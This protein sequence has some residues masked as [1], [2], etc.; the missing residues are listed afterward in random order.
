MLSLFVLFWSFVE[1]YSIFLV[2]FLFSIL[3]SI[4]YLLP[5][6][7][8]N[9]WSW[10]IS[11]SFLLSNHT[12]FKDCFREMFSNKSHCSKSVLIEYI[13][14]VVRVG[15][16]LGYLYWLGC[17]RVHLPWYYC[18]LLVCTHSLLVYQVWFIAPL[19]FYLVYCF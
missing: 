10:V 2:S 13:G 18:W 4:F 15:S 11:I 8:S 17:A 16:K 19:Y 7:S 9:S 14:M 5:S 3:L 1:V 12:R 6:I